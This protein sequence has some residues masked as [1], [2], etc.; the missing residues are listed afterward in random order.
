MKKEQKRKTLKQVAT[1]NIKL[2][3][4]KLDEELAK[5]L[6]NLYFV[7]EKKLKIGFKKNPKIHNINHANSIL[8]NIP[9]YTDFRSEIRYSNKISKEMA[10]IYARLINQY[11]FNYH[12]LFSAGFYKIIE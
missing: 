7:I 2:H 10:I 4:K 9:V 12:I 1:E 6:D 11:K 5:K 3:D 8:S